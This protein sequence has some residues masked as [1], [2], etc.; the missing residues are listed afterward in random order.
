MT[1]ITPEYLRDIT[2]NVRRLQIT[3]FHSIVKQCAD[4]V[5]SDLER[6][7]ISLARNGNYSAQS[8]VNICA[9]E[10]TE[11]LK[12]FSLDEF[13][14]NVHAKLR[15]YWLERGFSVPLHQS[16]YFEISWGHD[17]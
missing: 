7:L 1:Q 13:E 5:I 8:S 9:P 14:R 4:D 15:E 11:K 16:N 6:S 17:K 10:Y 12:N 2:D 3:D